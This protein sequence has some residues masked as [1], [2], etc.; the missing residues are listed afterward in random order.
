ML[1]VTAETKALLK[2]D[3]VYKEMLI[4]ITNG[5]TTY[6]FDNDS[7]YYE[8]FELS[9]SILDG[10]DMVFMGCVS[11]EMRVTVR[12]ENNLRESAFNNQHITVQVT[13]FANVQTKNKL[14][15]LLATGYTNTENGIS[16]VVNDD[17]SV[18]LNGTATENTSIMLSEYIADTDERLSLS[19][20]PFGGVLNQMQGVFYDQGVYYQDVGYANVVNIEAGDICKYWIFIAAGQT[21]SDVTF[22]PM[23]CDLS[24]SN[25]Y[26]PYGNKLVP[27]STIPLFNGYV[28][29]SQYHN[30]KGWLKITAYD[31]LY[32]LQSVNIWDWYKRVFTKDYNPSTHTWDDRSGSTIALDDMLDSLSDWLCDTQT[33]QLP[34]S[35]LRCPVILDMVKIKKRLSNKE[36]TATSFLKS[37]C[38][39]M[40]A[41][42]IIDR[43][44][45]L[46]LIYL[47]SSTQEDTITYY[48]S[49]TSKDYVVRPF[50]Q[51]ITIRTNSDDK[52]VT[53]TAP[54]TITV[55]WDD[56]S[57]DTYVVDDDDED[58]YV[59]KY[60]IDSNAL[61][62][63]LSENKRKAIINTLLSNV[64]TNYYT[65][66]S[67][68]LVCNG[69][70]YLECG[71]II[72]YQPTPTSTPI[73]LPIL[74]RKLTGIQ[75]MKDTFSFEIS[76]NSRNEYY[77]GTTDKKKDT[78]GVGNPNSNIENAS[79]E[80]NL[81]DYS[82]T[83][84]GT[85]QAYDYGAMGFKNV[86]INVSG[87]GGLQ[88]T[89]IST[90]ACT[91]SKPL[92]AGDC[93]YAYDGSSGGTATQAQAIFCN[94]SDNVMLA[95][96]KD[97]N[98]V[99]WV[100]YNIRSYAT[101]NIIYRVPLS[102][103]TGQSEIF[104]QGATEVF[105]LSRHIVNYYDDNYVEQTLNVFTGESESGIG[106][107]DDY[108]SLTQ[109]RVALYA[110]R[111]NF[112]DISDLSIKWHIAY[113]EYALRVRFIDDTYCVYID[114]GSFDTDTNRYAVMNAS[115]WYAE[116]VITTDTR[117][118]AA[119]TNMIGG[120][121]VC[122]K[123][124]A[125]ASGKYEVGYFDPDDTTG[126]FNN[127]TDDDDNNLETDTPTS[128]KFN[129]SGT[130][131]FVQLGTDGLATI[132]DS[133]SVTAIYTNIN[134]ISAYS[135]MFD[136]YFFDNGT[137]RLYYIP[138]GW[139]MGKTNSKSAR[140]QLGWVDTNVAQGETG[141]AYIL[142][143]N[144]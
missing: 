57:G 88:P 75:S 56:D 50:Q 74:N 30:D 49:L 98:N 71:D 35:I 135:E 67:Y 143:E 32:F 25:T 86:T 90:Q 96:G 82:F 108:G 111:V 106:R 127:I 125:N 36:M 134:G 38:Q 107:I 65:F 43:E 85:Y 73:R 46:Q 41:C 128:I 45:K 76:I 126:T 141:T 8:D 81:I 19:G 100:Y 7:I 129:D 4:T 1:N 110:G 117:F 9:E 95:L 42:A 94:L 14:P 139:V 52:G 68:E 122:F 132:D 77:G 23:L 60:Y 48:R 61:V 78:S 47:N 3:S 6:T 113:R 31:A 83:D 119:Y 80:S 59:G 130:K 103:M 40:C 37:L 64:Q 138:S 97:E 114:V 115:I 109:S 133:M 142:F 104:I 87:G 34:L 131:L 21:V 53:L 70:P 39:L 44:G 33:F 92:T 112:C 116:R 84:N 101:Q 58:F 69:L 91:A 20:C 10:S 24:E 89:A 11:N 120:K 144:N 118:L 22:Y 62:K 136:E 12:N 124:T 15:N 54:T 66:K 28:D 123:S 27:H 55:D 29:N 16:Y 18:T 17:L 140:G 51:G 102:N 99:R 72:S 137:H 2:T 93:V 79:S 26:E 63:K 121:L 13:P 5:S 105:A